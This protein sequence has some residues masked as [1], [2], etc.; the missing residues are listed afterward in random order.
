MTHIIKS[1]QELQKLMVP[2]AVFA[3]YEKGKYQ[4]P[5][6]FKIEDG[7]FLGHQQLTTNGKMHSHEQLTDWGFDISE[8]DQFYK[9]YPE[10]LL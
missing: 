7:N 1:L 8:L 4:F 5:S 2:E 10:Y 9:D 3:H 6:L